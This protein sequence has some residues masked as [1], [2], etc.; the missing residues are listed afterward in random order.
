MP[1]ASR[2]SSSG[3]PK[4][5]PTSTI[6]QTNADGFPDVEGVTFT[7]FAGG[8]KRG[9]GK[10]SRCITAREL[11]EMEFDPIKYVV[12]G[13]IAEDL[14]L[15]AGKPKL[16]KSWLVMD[17]ALAVASG[18]ICLGDVRCE[19]GAV[20]YLALEDNHRRLQS[21]IRKLRMLDAMAH[22]PVPDRLH[23]ATEWPRANEG[24]IDAI[25]AWIDAHAGARLVIVDVLA[26][27]KAMAARSVGNEKLRTPA[28]ARAVRVRHGVVE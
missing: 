13:Y 27:F 8:Q 6:G 21:R 17:I 4:P 3:R 10:T 2:P 22:K 5:E 12:P 26:M 9:N 19:H 1:P 20:L 23:L 28:L 11:C 14:T 15:L 7:S 25:R 24:G 18:G 16:G